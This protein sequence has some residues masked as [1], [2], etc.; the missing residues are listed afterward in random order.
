MGDRHT[1]SV[2]TAADF[3]PPTM[4]MRSAS[5]LFDRLDVL[6]V[7]L[8]ENTERWSVSA[9]GEVIERIL[10]ERLAL[11]HECVAIERELR[12]RTGVPGLPGAVADAGAHARRRAD[13][14]SA[15]AA[16][17]AAAAK[18][19][20]RAAAVHASAD[21][22]DL[23]DKERALAAKSALLER[24]ALARAQNY[25]VGAPTVPSVLR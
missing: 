4:W 20:E 16:V 25:A 2:G 15:V 9:G 13:A 7:L 11:H 1:A 14:S 5:A 23:A 3:S 22:P 10:E 6:H 17:H 19:H 21:R 12:L 18:M 24:E 8:A